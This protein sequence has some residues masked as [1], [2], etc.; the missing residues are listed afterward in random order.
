ML[1]FSGLSVGR[2]AFDYELD[3]DFFACFPEGEIRH[4]AVKV[5]LELERE[6]RLM[7]LQFEFRGQFE[8]ACDRCLRALACPVNFRDEV[9]VRFAGDADE[10]EDEDNL[11]WVEE[12]QDKLDL[13]Q[14]LYESVAL[15]RPIQMFCPAD[16]AGRPTCDEKMLRHFGP[17]E[18]RVEAGGWSEDNLAKLQAL[19]IQD[20]AELE[21]QK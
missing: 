16:E 14:Y 1:S 4:A 19:K 17:A 12:H 21:K 3:D 2:H 8:T 20:S 7:R 11:W 9:I 18:R 5:H 15:Q 6:E 13:S 10:R